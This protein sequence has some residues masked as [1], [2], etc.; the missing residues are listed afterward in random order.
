MSKNSQHIVKFQT[1]CFDFLSVNFKSLFEKQHSSGGICSGS[2]LDVNGSLDK[3]LPA[4]DR[5]VSCLFWIQTCTQLNWVSGAES[6][7][8]W[9]T[10]RT[11]ERDGCEKRLNG[12]D[13][14]MKA[15]S[16]VLGAGCWCGGAIEGL[17]LGLAVDWW[18]MT[19]DYSCHYQ[20]KAAKGSFSG[21]SN[22][23]L[24]SRTGQQ[25]HEGY[26]PGEKSIQIYTCHALD[27]LL[28]MDHSFNIWKRDTM[29]Y[30]QGDPE[31]FAAMSL[32]TNIIGDG[33]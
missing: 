30:F 15:G 8:T 19:L 14:K 32:E 9:G 25:H 11:N 26:S 3:S 2:P 24:F 7:P 6:D 22:T 27:I 20:S 12:G 28:T 21:T 10:R 23:P 5:D 17:M 31:Q 4:S 1:H 18:G 16:G 13:V 33:V 29:W